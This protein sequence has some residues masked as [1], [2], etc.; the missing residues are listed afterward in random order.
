MLPLLAYNL[1]R[2]LLW[3]AAEQYGVD[4]LRLS[5]QNAL[6]HL[7]HFLPQLVNFAFQSRTV[8]APDNPLRFGSAHALFIGPKPRQTTIRGTERLPK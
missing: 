3:Q 5:L 2:S 7:R 1:M 6:R 8:A 4:P